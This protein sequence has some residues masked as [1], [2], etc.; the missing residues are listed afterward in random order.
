MPRPR[1]PK[2]Q[3]KPRKYPS[4]LSNRAW[5]HLVK[6]LPQP[7]KKSG[8]VGRPP[9]ELRAVVNAILY[10]VRSGCAWAML[11]HDY[12]HYKTVYGYFWRWSRDGTWVRVHTRLVKK[13]RRK[14]R[15]KRR[16]SAGSLD[17]QSVK[18]TQVGGERGFDAG[19]L[20]KG[21]KRFI[22]VD[23][24]GWMLGVRVVAASVR[25]AAQSEKA[26]AM[27]LL[28]HL[29]EVPCLADLCRRLKLIWADGAYQGPDLQNWVAALWGW[30]WQIVKRNDNQ[31]GFVVLP[32]RWVVERTF[33]WL[34]FN[35]RL[36]KDYEK[37]ACHSE[38]MIYVASIALLV[39]RL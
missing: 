16:P 34:S 31:K 10:V 39:K 25:N 19:K 26:G 9:V 36:S 23:T 38:S 17:S 37:L 18:T 27:L 14:A 2:Q 5:Q 6:V 21:R 20:I 28:T 35:R 22:L 33:A 11:P 30:V 15:R 12:P 4:Q 13:R 24:Q 29:K 1:T 8:S 3:V 7:V 32:R